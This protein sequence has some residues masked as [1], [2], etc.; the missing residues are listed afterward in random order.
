[1]KEFF[2][3]TPLSEVLAR[4]DRFPPVAVETVPLE[5]S[6][7]RVL[8]EEIVSDIDIPEFG[9][10]TMDG[11]AV[12]AAATF[13][14]SEANPAYLTVV[15]QVPMG[16]KPDFSVSPGQAA[17]IATGGML[18]QGCDS[19]VMIEHT[20][21]VDDTL[22]EVYKS[23][24]PGQHVIERG[25]D[26]AA[27]RPVLTPGR[28]LRPQEMGLL[29][30][31]GRQQVAVFRRPVVAIISTGDEL[32][33]VD[34]VPGTGQVRD[35]NSYSL[36]AQVAQAGAQ[37]KILGIVGD[38]HEAL[39]ASC[40]KALEAADMVLIS[41][42][43]SVGTRDLT[44][45][46][47]EALADARILIHGIGI[48]PG[49][50]TIMACCGQKALW[51]L[52]GHAV[53]AMVVFM[54]V[55]R[56]HLWHICGLRGRGRAPLPVKARLSRN[57]SAKQGRVDYLRIR[58]QQRQDTLW[59]DPILGKSGLIRTMVAADGLLAIDVDV[60]G[61]DKGSWVEVLPL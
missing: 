57:V 41:G 28:L 18:P 9:R 24:A 22:I 14:A 4:V 30:A 3:I 12:P 37:A 55:V 6:H 39:L 48:S 45:Q 13:G 51:G 47:I 10:S 7:G 34:Q 32:V 15:G 54:T 43:S 17:R 61:L 2:K 29:A 27:G 46:V 11:F 33:P 56:P 23:V 1:M 5:R 59:A 35:I 52:P 36:A 49:K 26:I 8:A 16:K 21:A 60:E 50:P 20:D 42:G 25:E 19:V 53:S 40:R 44:V 31:A 58:L 38:R